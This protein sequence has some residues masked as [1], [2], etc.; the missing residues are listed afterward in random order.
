[1]KWLF[2]MA[3]LMGCA[4]CS[5][6]PVQPFPAPY[7]FLTGEALFQ[8]IR[9]RIDSL[10]NASESE[11]ES[12][13]ASSEE[14]ASLDELAS[15]TRNVG[16]APGERMGLVADFH[17]AA[18]VTHFGFEANYHALVFFQASGKPFRIEKW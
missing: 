12:A 11:W 5:K 13:A 1:M 10:E 14:V 16:F 9:D 3:A 2:V 8:P 6:P 7:E 15:L 4:G 18:R 17:R